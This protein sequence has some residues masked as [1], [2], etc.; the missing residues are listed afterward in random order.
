MQD[1][2]PELWL[3]VLALLPRETLPAISLTNRRFRTLT[4]PLLFS[5]FEFHPYRRRNGEEPAPTDLEASKKRLQF[6]CREDIAQLVRSCVASPW[7]RRRALVRNADFPLLDQ[8]MAQ[9]QK[10]TALKQ[11]VLANVQTS[12]HTYALLAGL[13]S[14]ESAEICSCNFSDMEPLRQ[15]VGPASLMTVSTF[16]FTSSI[17]AARDPLHSMVPFLPTST[18]LRLELVCDLRAWTDNPA[19]VPAFPS[20]KHLSLHANLELFSQNMA[21]LAHFPALQYL[22]L[23]GWGRPTYPDT[24][25]LESVCFPHLR[26]LETA[27]RMLPLL[28][29]SECTPSL[30]A[31]NVRFCSDKTPS[32]TMSD[33]PECGSITSLILDLGYEVDIDDEGYDLCDTLRNILVFFPGLERLSVELTADVEGDL[34]FERDN[35]N[36]IPS[37]FFSALPSATDALPQ[38]LTHIAFK[39]TFEYDYEDAEPVYDPDAVDFDAVRQA[40]AGRCPQLQAL[41]LDG[42]MFCYFWDK[43][44]N[45]SGLEDGG[46]GLAAARRLLEDREAKGY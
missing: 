42:E 44:S 27:R 18:L 22:H 24:F 38:S 33:I 11:L 17:I 25:S 19:L 32:A 6:W 12:V 28:L 41:W 29:R 13:R 16:K 14:L 20:V 1:L 30:T 23:D 36:P 37:K 45:T 43:I 35:V 21:I 9:L 46:E 5:H 2:A 31:L 26:C 34:L 10:F 8:L 4:K 3:E 40:L 15:D 39:W 7:D